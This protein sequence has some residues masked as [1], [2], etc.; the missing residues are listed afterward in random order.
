MPWKNLKPEIPRERLII[1]GFYEANINEEFLKNFL[2]GLSETLKM[3][4]I[5]GPFIFSPDRFSTLHHGIGGFMAWAESGVALYSWR[6]HK[7]FTIDIYSCKAFN[8]QQA[9]EYVKEKLKSPQIVWK[10]IEYDE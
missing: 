8:M 7:F 3:K 4:V 5:A 1:E 2:Q 9:I 6:D 10:K